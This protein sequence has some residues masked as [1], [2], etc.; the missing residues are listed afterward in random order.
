MKL[1]IGL[2]L[3]TVIVKVYNVKKVRFLLLLFIGLEQ[4]L[5]KG[6][7]ETGEKEK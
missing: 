6:D 3:M 2:K 7:L 5:K 1:R 4:L